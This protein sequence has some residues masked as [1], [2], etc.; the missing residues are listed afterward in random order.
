[1]VC[2]GWAAVVLIDDMQDSFKKWRVFR[3]TGPFLFRALTHTAQ[4]SFWAIEK[5]NLSCSP[6]AWVVGPCFVACLAT[7]GGIPGVLVI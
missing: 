2:V 5:S 4:K 6:G 1:M 7:Q 3:E